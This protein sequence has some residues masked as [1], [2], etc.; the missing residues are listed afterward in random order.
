MLPM[1]VHITIQ[2]K[3]TV[4]L[5]S[6]IQILYYLKASGI[7]IITSSKMLSTKYTNIF[8][9]LIVSPTSRVCT[10]TWDFWRNIYNVLM[11]HTLKKCVPGNVSITLFDTGIINETWGS[12]ILYFYS[13]EHV[14]QFIDVYIITGFL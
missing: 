6:F 10:V 7:L 1:E 8:V 9:H 14:G 3:N 13:M 2:L 11:E 5:N 12:F 4:N